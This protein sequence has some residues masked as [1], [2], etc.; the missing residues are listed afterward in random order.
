MSVQTY[1]MIKIIKSGVSFQAE[2]SQAV[3]PKSTTNMCN[4]NNPQLFV[5]LC[6]ILEQLSLKLSRCYTL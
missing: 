3:S 2:L 1:N 4:D 5:H 6:V